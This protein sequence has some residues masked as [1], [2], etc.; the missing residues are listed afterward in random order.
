[1]LLAFSKVDRFSIN[2]Y[3]EISRELTKL[4]EGE[5]FSLYKYRDDIIVLLERELDLPFTDYVDRLLDRLSMDTVIYV[6]RHEMR[7]P[8][9]LIT[10]H[11]PGN[12]GEAEYGGKPKAVSLSNAKLQSEALRTLYTLAK[13]E[14]LTGEYEVALEAT[15]H[16]P[17]LDKYAL[18]IEVGSTDRE[19][20]D[21]RCVKIFKIFIENLLEILRK[22]T[23]NNLSTIVSIGDLHY[24][25]ITHHVLSNK[26]NVGHIIPK[27]VSIDHQVVHMCVNRTKPRPD[28]AVIHWKSLRKDTRDLVVN[29]LNRLGIN[30][31]KRK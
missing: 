25:T 3:R 10:V 1:M 6:S 28:K 21:S 5:T 31:V 14:D 23:H 4:S 17:S 20:N 7:N 22:S 13:E 9:P 29:V 2:V 26:Y 8:R 18:F 11:T 19:W 27:Y 15:H 24:S 16:G 30:V 12:W